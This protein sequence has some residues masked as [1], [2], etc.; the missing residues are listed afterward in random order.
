MARKKSLFD[1]LK[2]GDWE[3][4]GAFAL[5]ALICGLFW[6][7]WNQ[8]SLAHWEYSIPWV[9]RFHLFQMPLLGYAGYL[10]FGWECAAIGRYVIPLLPK[11][12]DL[13]VV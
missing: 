13:Y 9:D 10:T 5:A 12:K 1:S 2:A 6:E 8:F 4:L 3:P 11:K 7:M